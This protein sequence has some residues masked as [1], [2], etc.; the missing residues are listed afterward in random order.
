MNRFITL[1]ITLLLSLSGFAKKY[2]IENIPMVHLQDETRYVCNPDNVLDWSAVAKMDAQLAELED[3]TGIEV[4]VVAVDTLANHDCYETAIRLGQKYG[5]GKK[6][7]NNGLVIML[8]TSD[9]CVQLVIGSGLEGYLPDAI[10]KRIQRE[11]MNPYFSKGDWSQG[12][13]HGVE[14]V[15]EILGGSMRYEDP[16][17]L[18]GITILFLCAFFAIPFLALAGWW[19]AKKCPACGKHKLRLDHTTKVYSDSKMVKYEDVF[20]CKSC[21]ESVVRLRTM[22]KASNNIRYNG[23][24]RRG[25]GGFGG[26]GGGYSGGSIGGSFGGGRFGGGGAG[27][28]F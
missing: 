6:S 27:S 11:D 21:G 16:M 12:M 15:C 26:F 13:S 8:S 2:T 5:V 28:R 7:L 24:G 17:E 20:I 3:S 18:D 23:G 14:A 10:C 1:T 9:R 25:G 19:K 22:Y 4:V